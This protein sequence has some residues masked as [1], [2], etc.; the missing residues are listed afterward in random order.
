MKVPILTTAHH[1]WQ[2]IIKPGDR[3]IDATCGNGLDT[4]HLANLLQNSGALFAYDIQKK[5]IEETQKKTAHFSNIIYKNV[6][7][8]SFEE[9]DVKLIVYNLGYLPGSDK[10]ITTLTETTLQSLESAKKALSKGG[11]LSIVCYPGHKE[12]AKEAFFVERWAQEQNCSLFIERSPSPFLLI[13]EHFA[14]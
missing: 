11:A 4:L 7:H 1:Y 12:G 13:L 10:T 3:V 14:S 5:A 9:Q 6:S 8:A 2:K